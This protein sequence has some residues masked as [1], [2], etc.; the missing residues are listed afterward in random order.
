MFTVVLSAC[1][2]TAVR[3]GLL[4]TNP[5][6]RVEKVPSPGESD[7]GIALD[8]DELRKLIEGFRGSLHYTRS[9]PRRCLQAPGATKF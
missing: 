1:L 2:G 8:A 6:A 3:K 7:H 5:M 9:S 4:T